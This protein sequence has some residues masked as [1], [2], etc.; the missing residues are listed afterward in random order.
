MSTN[1]EL[2]REIC[3]DAV[4]AEFQATFDM[5]IDLAYT[6]DNTLDVDAIK[7]AWLEAWISEHKTKGCNLTGK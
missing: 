3:K 7:S 5:L 4:Y 2:A 1:Q 6:F